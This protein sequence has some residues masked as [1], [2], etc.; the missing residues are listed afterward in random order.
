MKILKKNKGVLIFYLL[1]V[2]ITLAVV[3]RNEENINME[4]RYVYLTRYIF[5]NT[6]FQNP[7]NVL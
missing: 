6:S 5:F 3:E 1:L 4:N 7:K 2:V